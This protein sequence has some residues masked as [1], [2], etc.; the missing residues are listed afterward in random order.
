VSENR[1]AAAF[2]R[3]ERQGRAAFI[4]Y[5]T[6]GDPAAG[7]TLALARALDRAGA[8][9]LELGVPFSD[10]IA[11]GRVLQRAAERSLGA[12][13]TLQEVWRLARDIRRESGI[14]LVL[15][16]YVNPLLRRGLERAAKEARAAGFDAVLVT[17]LPPEE[18]GHVQPVFR[19]AGL[20][21]VFL[22]SPTSSPDRMSRAARLSS[23]FLYVV[24]RT[25]TTGERDSLP[26]DL[27]VTVARAR[28]AGSRRGTSRL[29]VAVGFGVSSPAVARAASRLADGVVVGSALV[30]AAEADGAEA[31]ERL[32]RRLARAC[33]R[34]ARRR[35]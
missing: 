32:A 26:P 31:F 33:R 15:F 19:T 27:P 20:D 11:D 21:T 1:I 4:P 28:R 13:T 8:D 16:S 7:G 10:P 18:A 3:A 29:P 17:D 14:A 30:A 25:G 22:V 2:E 34:E 6:A 24:S 9:V 5:L 35:S 12:G 23:G